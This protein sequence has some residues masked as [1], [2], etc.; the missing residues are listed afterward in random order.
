MAIRVSRA[1]ARSSRRS[2]SRSHSLVAGPATSRSISMRAFDAVPTTTLERAVLRVRLNGALVHTEDIRGPVA[3]HTSI[4]LPAPLV[5]VGNRLEV[6]F[7]Y[8]P[9]TGNCQG[10]PY[11]MTAQLRR[12]SA[13]TWGG[14]GGTR[15]RLGEVI[16]A[17]R[18]P[19]VARTRQ[20]HARA[21][22]DRGACAWRHRR[23][24][25]VPDRRGTRAARS[26]RFAFRRGQESRRRAGAL[27]ARAGRRARRGID[28][29]PP[30]QGLAG[31][32]ARRTEY[33]PDHRHARAPGVSRLHGRNRHHGFQRSVSDGQWL[34]A[35]GN[36]LVSNGDETLVLDL[37]SGSLVVRPAGG[38]SVVLGVAT[39][40]DFP[41]GSRP[42]GVPALLAVRRGSAAVHRFPSVRTRAEC[43]RRTADRRPKTEDRL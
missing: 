37:A 18:R 21:R 15:G 26:G 1:S 39:V 29:P 35:A 30:A 9:V 11:T 3:L 28:R 7:F 14:L 24:D 16:T 17:G 5:D 36:T 2:G 31:S 32:A 8:A 4:P 42:R 27:D 34:G 38:A 19:C 13:L 41:R 6:E 25:G 33:L 40:A 22:T 43:C 12:T 20:R 10:S 23:L